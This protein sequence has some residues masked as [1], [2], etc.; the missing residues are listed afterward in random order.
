MAVAPI[1]AHMTKIANVAAVAVIVAA[2]CV[3]ARAAAQGNP[4]GFAKTIDRADATIWHFP[5]S[6]TTCHD[7]QAAGQHGR[8]ICTINLGSPNHSIPLAPY[9]AQCIRGEFWPAGGHIK[10]SIRSITAIPCSQT[11]PSA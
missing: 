6:H 3:V 9:G 10:V 2:L 1:A 5:K 7:D 8:Y 11:S 4:H